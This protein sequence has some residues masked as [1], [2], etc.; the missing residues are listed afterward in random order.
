MTS[1]SDVCRGRRKHLL[2]L[3]IFALIALL[4]QAYTSSSGSARAVSIK[5]AALVSARFGWSGAVSLPLAVDA[6]PIWWNTNAQA[7]RNVSMMSAAGVRQVRIDAPWNVLEPAKG[8]YSTFR[9][10][11][12][13]YAIKA[14]S[15]RGITVLL[16]AT[17]TPAWA[18]GGS[19]NYRTPPQS[20]AVFAAY[21]K[22][23]VKRYDGKI[24]GIEIWN[25]PNSTSSWINPDA[26]SYVSLLKASYPAVK[27][28]DRHVKVL[29]ASLSNLYALPYLQAMYAAGA[30]RYF[31]VLSVHLYTRNTNSPDSLLNQAGQSLSSL[32]AAQADS[33]REIWVTELGYPTFSGT[34]GV[35]ES[36]QNAFL[37][38]ARQVATE[39]PHI[40]RLYFYEWQ[41]DAGS[42][43]N[44]ESHYGLIRQDFSMK[45]ALEGLEAQT[46]LSQPRTRA[47]RF[48]V[49]RR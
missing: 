25:E 36:A 16:V 26:K 1:R 8:V 49:A 35:S 29:G 34:Y 38:S 20:P 47:P 4:A 3:W 41:D 39:E 31:D 5:H 6:H 15:A 24:E 28:V 27:S 32:L 21:V 30:K 2:G 18:N 14:F 7:D 48:G 44:P 13:D 9:F 22:Y 43:T 42:P 11:R 45:P 46:R 10:Q 23:L 12:L 40:T 37:R 33:A 19:A 17:Y